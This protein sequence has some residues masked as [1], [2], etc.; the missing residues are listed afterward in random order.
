[1]S[2]YSHIVDCLGENGLDF[3]AITEMGKNDFLE[4]ALH[5]GDLYMFKL[6]FSEII[7]LPNFK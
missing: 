5:N 3:V 1:L 2:R 4:H 7:I 6:N